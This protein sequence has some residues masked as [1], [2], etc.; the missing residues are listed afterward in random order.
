MIMH[1]GSTALQD[2]KM[3]TLRSTD[4]VAMT[5]LIPALAASSSFFLFA[6]LDPAPFEPSPLTGTSFTTLGAHRMQLT[7]WP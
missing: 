2:A 7:K 4:P 3:R 6:V 5:H 1:H